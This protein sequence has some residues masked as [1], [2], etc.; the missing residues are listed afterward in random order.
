MEVLQTK[1]MN[2]KIT[3]YKLSDL[4][5]GH[6]IYICMHDLEGGDSGIIMKITDDTILVDLYSRQDD[7]GNAW[8]VQENKI[9]KKSDIYAVELHTYSKTDSTLHVLVKGWWFLS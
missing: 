2:T 9:I 5:V 7:H 1:H 3:Q 4:A 8:S 6:D